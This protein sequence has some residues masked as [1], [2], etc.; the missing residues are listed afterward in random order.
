L[1][2]LKRIDLEMN[3]N[4]PLPEMLAGNPLMF[5]YPCFVD[6]STKNLIFMYRGL[7]TA[8]LVTHVL[9]IM[10]D[11]LEEDKQSKK[12][13]KKVFNVMIECLRNVYSEDNASE[14]SVP[15]VSLEAVLIVRKDEDAYFVTTGN[16]VLNTK[17]DPLRSKLEKV[18]EMDSESLKVY[19]QELLTDQEEDQKGLTILGIIDI[20]RK[21]K[22]KVVYSFQQVN[23]TLT[24]FS[25]E[26]K[27]D[28]KSL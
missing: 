4:N 13:S 21:S 22:Q 6:M 28:K 7:V 20:A 25:L 23:E 14:A 15:K 12:V 2:E 26:A 17:V 5:A 24:F 18:N 27:I 1:P 19:Y 16:Y 9:Q 10:E 8:D 11:R 3:P